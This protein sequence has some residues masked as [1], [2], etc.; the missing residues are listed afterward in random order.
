VKATDR[1]NASLCNDH[2]AIGSA[3]GAETAAI[4][5]IIVSLFQVGSE[6]ALKRT[7]EVTKNIWQ[8]SS[9]TFKTLKIHVVKSSFTVRSM[10]NSLQ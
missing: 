7:A 9:T 1:L 2:L 5:I 3:C 6:P 4:M 10:R 8:F